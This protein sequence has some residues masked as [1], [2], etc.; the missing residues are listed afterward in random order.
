MLPSNTWRPWWGFSEAS[1]SPSWTSKA[2]LTLLHKTGA[3]ALWS[4]LWPSSGP[5]PTAPHPSWAGGPQAWMQSTRWGLKR[6]EQRGTIPSLFLL[7]PPCWGSPG[8][9]WPSRL[10]EHT[11]SSC[12][13]R[14]TSPP[15]DICVHD[16]P[17]NLCLWTFF[18]SHSCF[19]TS[20]HTVR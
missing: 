5:A 20:A 16:M 7:P 6:A 18:N 9:H 14:P 17:F 3:P 11:A 13:S 1:S 10:Q 2:P 8:Y 15:Q 4:S 19:Q 12:P